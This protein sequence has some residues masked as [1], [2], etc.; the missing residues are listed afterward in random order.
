VAT[1]FFHF[2]SSSTLQQLRVLIALMMVGCRVLCVVLLLLFSLSMTRCDLL[3]ASPS[4]LSLF[5]FRV[6]L[7][8]CFLCPLDWLSLFCF[9]SLRCS[10]RQPHRVASPDTVTLLHRAA[11]QWR[12]ASE[13]A[14]A[15]RIAC[16]HDERRPLPAARPP[17]PML[18]VPRRCLL[19]LDSTRSRTQTQN[20]TTRH[21]HALIH[22]PRLH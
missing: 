7:F 22:P 6:V 2:L 3:V 18:P 4:P 12:G 11:G 16:T 21:D 15:L 10:S 19:R 14:D 13:R 20:S 5:S 17:V 8:S 1:L 9:R